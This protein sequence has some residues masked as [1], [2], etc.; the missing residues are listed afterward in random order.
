MNSRSLRSGGLYEPFKQFFVFLEIAGNKRQVNRFL[1]QGKQTVRSP[2]L[3][4]PSLM[5]KS[6]RSDK[7][8]LTRKNASL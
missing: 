6:V 2:P 1:G 5:I 7:D 3:P 8:P 4:V